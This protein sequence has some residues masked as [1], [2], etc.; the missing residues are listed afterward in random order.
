[1]FWKKKSSK[2][3][4]LLE[5]A[6]DV[7]SKDNDSELEE[8]CEKYK[9]EIKLQFEGWIPAPNKYRSSQTIINLYGNSLVSIAKIFSQ[10]GD[11]SLVELLSSD[12]KSTR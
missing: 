2:Q 8:F 11:N 9:E 4:D 10:N 12:E 6:I 5:A 3:I 7:T 1:M